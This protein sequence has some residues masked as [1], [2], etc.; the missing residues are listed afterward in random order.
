[1]DIGLRYDYSTRFKEQYGRSPDFAP[2][3]ANPSAGGH[4]G[5]VIY[6]ATCGCRFGKKLPGAFGPRF[7]AAYQL[8]N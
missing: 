5:A 8:R 6:E 1:L 4:P 7:G 2:D 3:V